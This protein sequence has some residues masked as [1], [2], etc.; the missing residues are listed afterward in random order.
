MFAIKL[1]D[2]SSEESAESIAKLLRNVQC[3]NTL[4]K[5]RLVV[6]GRQVVDGA[7]KESEV[8]HSSQCGRSKHYR[9]YTYTAS[10]APKI[11]RTANSWPYVFTAAVAADIVPQMTTATQM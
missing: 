7:R 2:G 1:K 8:E 11:A 10:A 9:G 5:F 3:S 4:S 6:P